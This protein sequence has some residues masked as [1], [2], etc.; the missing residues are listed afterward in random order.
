MFIVGSKENAISVEF[1]YVTY[2]LYTGDPSTLIV[3]GWA[4]TYGYRSEC[5]LEESY[6]TYNPLADKFQLSSIQVNDTVYLKINTD[7]GFPGFPSA[8]NTGRILH[9]PEEINGYDGNN[10]FLGLVTNLHNQNGVIYSWYRNNQIYL[11]APNQCLLNITEPGNY[12]CKVI[13]GNTEL[14]S[15]TVNVLRRTTSTFKGT[16]KDTVYPSSISLECLL[17][18]RKLV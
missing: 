7:A 1:M 2:S 6:E 13:H 5:W 12:F 11:S 16:T 18:N 9:G 15:A 8:D 14:Q 3:N 4:S 10:F 17:K